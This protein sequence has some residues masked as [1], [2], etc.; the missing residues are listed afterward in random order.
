MTNTTT[1][2]TDSIILTVTEV[3]RPEDNHGSVVTFVGNDA[4]GENIFFVVDHRPAAVILTLLAEDGEVSVAVAP[5]QVI[6]KGAF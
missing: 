2:D 1:S 5:W 6:G 4:D 3:P